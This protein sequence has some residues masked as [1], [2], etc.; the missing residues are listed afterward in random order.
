MASITS[1][2]TIGGGSSSSSSNNMEVENDNNI[3]NNNSS[4]VDE[5][6][7]HVKD[8]YNIWK[9]NVPF[10]YDYMLSHALEWPSLTCQWLP[11]TFDEE[12]DST[13]TRQLLLGSHVAEGKGD[14]EL[15]ISTVTLPKNGTDWQD[16]KEDAGDEEKGIAIK[17][18]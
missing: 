3:D 11:D 7:Q 5:D 12:T 18:L 10:L 16:I 1:Q 14:N 8:E 9:K 17:L 4:V 2:N 15:L 13:I 6:Q